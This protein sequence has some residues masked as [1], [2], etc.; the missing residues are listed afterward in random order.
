MFSKLST[1]VNQLL[2]KQGQKKGVKT[3]FWKCV[4]LDYLFISKDNLKSSGEILSQKKS[5][6]GQKCF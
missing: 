1:T 4:K 2:T 6:N 5:Y 3:T